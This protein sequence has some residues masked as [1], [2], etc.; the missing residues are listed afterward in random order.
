MTTVSICDGCGDQ[1]DAE[2][3]C[4]V[5]TDVHHCSGCVERGVCSGC[6]DAARD[7]EA[8]DLARDEALS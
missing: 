2:D 5:Q 7:A 8:E 6:R 3:E 1:C 4:V